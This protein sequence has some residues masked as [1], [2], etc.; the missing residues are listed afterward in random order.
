MPRG[1]HKSMA[2]KAQEQYEKQYEKVEKLVTKRK[3]VMEQVV[4]LNIRIR[5]EE[6]MLEYYAKH[7]LVQVHEDVLPLEE[8]TEEFNVA[9][10][11][12]GLRERHYQES[13]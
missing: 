12:K 5:D 9:D 8:D 4:T 2:E 1:V 11:W 6:T 13:K 7:P 3:E 10:A